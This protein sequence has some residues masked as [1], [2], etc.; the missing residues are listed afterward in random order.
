MKIKSISE[1]KSTFLTAK[2]SYIHKNPYYL[3]RETDLFDHGIFQ[4]IDFDIF[5]RLDFDAGLIQKEKEHLIILS[6]GGIGAFLG[7]HGRE[8]FNGLMDYLSGLYATI[9]VFLLR[10]EIKEI[11]LS[12]E[13]VHIIDPKDEPLIMKPFE[14]REFEYYREFFPYAYSISNGR[15]SVNTVLYEMSDGKRKRLWEISAALN[16]KPGVAKV[17]LDRMMECGLIMKEDKVYFIPSAYFCAGLSGARTEIM[18]TEASLPKKREKKDE[19]KK[20]DF[21]YLN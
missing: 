8:A 3:S 11:G 2:I 19:S 17:Y 13:E 21:D 12:E 14:K 20:S 5:N 4:K 6:N 1:L 15:L 18:I 7:F 16:K 9:A 10:N